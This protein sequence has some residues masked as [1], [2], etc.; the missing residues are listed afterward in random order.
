MVSRIR[1]QVGQLNYPSCKKQVSLYN[2]RKESWREM[3]QQRGKG[4]GRRFRGVCDTCSAAR[5]HPRGLV[6][7]D[8]KESPFTRKIGAALL[9]T[10]FLDV[11]RVSQELGRPDP[12]N[13]VVIVTPGDVN[14]LVRSE[15]LL[16]VVKQYC[17]VRRNW[18]VHGKTKR[19]RVVHGRSFQ[20]QAEGKTP[21]QSPS[22]HFADLKQCRPND[23]D[24][25]AECHA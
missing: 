10:G 15:N 23:N 6:E 16:F 14:I 11:H 3:V 18:L 12:R 25:N 5:Q 8:S 20:I 7:R 21:D 22:K 24:R 13:V 9:L 19:C 1:L 4:C 17:R 2:V